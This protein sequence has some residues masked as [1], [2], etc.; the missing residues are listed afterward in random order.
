MSTEDTTSNEKLAGFKNGFFPPSKSKGCSTQYIKSICVRAI[1]SRLGHLTSR[2]NAATNLS[3]KGL[4]R[5]VQ[6]KRLKRFEMLFGRNVCIGRPLALQFQ[7]LFYHVA[8][9]S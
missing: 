9:A 1:K 7:D 4:V 5:K 8:N 2:K 3:L 6:R